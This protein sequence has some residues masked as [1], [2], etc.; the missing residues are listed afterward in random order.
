MRLRS[1][2]GGVLRGR[3]G[4]VSGIAAILLPVTLG[5]AGLVI[6]HGRGLVEKVEN[7]RIADLS[8]YA[9]AVAYNTTVSQNAM[10]NAAK[11][12]AALNGIPA[13]SVNV[14][15]VTSP[16][17]P[18]NSAV[19]V[20]VTTNVTMMLSRVVGAPA[21]L[22]VPAEAFAELR[23]S[24]D[25]CILALAASGGGVQMIGGAQLNAPACVTA[26]NAAISVPCGTGLRAVGVAYNS[27][28]LP[29][30]PCGGIQG[31]NGSAAT[32]VK[33]VTNDPLAGNADIATARARLVPVAALTA[34]G[35]PVGPGVPAIA[36][37]TGTFLDIELGYDDAKTKTQAIALG[38]T[39]TKS[40]ST[41]TL[42][43]PPGDH[44]FKTV[45]VGGGLAV[46]FV[47]N[48]LTNNFFSMAMST[49]PAINFGNAN[50]LFMQG[51]TIGYGG[52]TFGTGTLNVIGG[53]STGA[54]TTIGSTNVS[55]TGDAT[56][57][58]TTRLTGNGRLWVGGNLT[59]K[60]TPSI[61]QP[62]IRVGGN[63]AVTSPSAFNS[64]T[65]LSVG[66]AMTIGTYGTMSFGGGTWN[67]VGGLTT[68]GSST[69]T[70]GAGNFT[71]GR[72]ASTCSGAQFSLC[73]SAAS[74]I[75]AGPSSFVLQAGV[76]ATG[77]SILVLGS[78]GT[79]NSFRIGASTN[80][81]A[82]QIG[83]GATFR[84]GDATGVSSI[85]E[86]GGHLNI[87]SGG[88]SCTVIGAA[89]QH[90]IAGSIL[91]AGATVLGAGV[92]TVTGS[93]GIGA[94]GGGNV[95]CNG[96]NTGLLANGVSMIV[97]AAGAALTGAC[98]EQAF[99]V[100]AGYQTVVVT[101]PTAGTYKRL[102]VVGPATG[103]RG[104]YFAQGASATTLSGLFYFPV[105]AIR[106]DGAASVGN[107]AGECLQLIG[108]EITLSG[109]SLL[110][111]TCISG[112][113]SGGK[114]VLIK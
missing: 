78:S 30:Q 44:R 45:S 98:A 53:L 22:A 42:N 50:Y 96:A 69:I 21:T 36:A 12:V 91:T 104:A 61:A 90:D 25:S 58:S 1:I 18:A 57:N 46:E 6:E 82:V 34:P 93:I 94:N 72:S 75:F 47:G 33:K 10:T 76:A 39:A 67:I 26:S 49:G 71:I 63:F 19:R 14:A 38:C 73:S 114:V 103:A 105:G 64:I 52:V 110:A 113:A 15:L 74:L 31:P 106:F 111:S 95:M 68:G 11:A 35:A 100:A 29:S 20:T 8:A 87:A 107:G 86:L 70:I 84:T 97:G 65:Q 83:G 55:V 3:G 24:V 92:Y 7:Q 85:F 17:A 43:C 54:T 77:G 40:G 51:L 99:C 60:D 5:T 28:A 37:P 66:G 32:I 62:E 56:F 80:G 102:V 2:F 88:G 59:T 27:A 9:G 4:A 109:G 108:K 81:N 112:T 79:T 16:A 23:P 13:A 89:S 41:W 101:T 48:S